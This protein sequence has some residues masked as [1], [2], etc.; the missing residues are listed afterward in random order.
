MKLTKDRLLTLILISVTFVAVTVSG[1]IYKQPVYRIIPLY[2]TLAVAALQSKANR[3]A[4]LIGCFNSIFY[5]VVYFALGLYATAAYWG[6]VAFPVQLITFLLWKK[7]AYRHSTLLRKMSLK[8][9]LCVAAVFVIA[10]IV[11]YFFLP[12]EDSALNVLDTISSLTGVLYFYL[13]LMAFKEYPYLW[14]I[15]VVITIIL[16]GAMLK[17]YP[18]QITFMFSYCYLLCTAL[19]SIPYVNRLYKEQQAESSAAAD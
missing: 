19:R 4:S 1:I 8:H 17:E 14:V 18:G 13:T 11:T 6:L 9:G 12:S 7:N 15:N 10:F 16:N 3:F 2:V 5:T